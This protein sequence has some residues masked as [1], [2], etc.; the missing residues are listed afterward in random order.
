MDQNNSFDVRE[1][2]SEEDL[3]K[4]NRK[5]NII[6]FIICVLLAFTLWLMIRNADDEGKGD[7]LPPVNNEQTVEQAT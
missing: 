1:N 6:A 4:K 7:E 3:A 2:I 5:N